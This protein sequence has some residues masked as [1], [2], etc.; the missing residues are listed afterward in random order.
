MTVELVGLESAPILA[1]DGA[2]ALGKGAII[3]AMLVSAAFLAGLAVLKKSSAAFCGFLMVVAA[4][5][6]QAVWL[7]VGP[8]PSQAILYLLQGL[9]AASG[10]LFISSTIGLIARSQLL[11]GILFA[12]ALSLVGVGVLN[13]AFGGE[14]AGLQR[15]AMIAAAAVTIGLA[16]F[17]G[18]RGDIGARLIMPGAALAAAAPLMLGVAGG[19]GA[20]SL[21]PQ[22]VFA[23]GV[24]VASL[25]ALGEFGGGRNMVMT[26]AGVASYFGDGA[27]AE[28]DQGSAHHRH[29]MRVAETKLAQVLDYAGIAVWDWSR[30]DSNQTATFGAVM[31]ADGDGAFTPE[32]FSEFIHADDR[33]RF[34]DKVFGV[35]EGDGGFDETIKLHSGKKVRMRGARAVDYAGRLERIVVFLEDSTSVA[36]LRRDDALKLAATSLTSA[37]AAAAAPAKDNKGARSDLVAAIED[38]GI[39]AAFQPI[40]SFDDGRVCGAEALLRWPSSDKHGA[41]PATEE[42]V[43]KAQAAGKG[44]AIARIMLD[45][46]AHH[47]CERLSTGDKSYFTAFNVSVSQVREPGF[48]DDVRKA[49]ADHKL[50]KGALVLEL[51]EGERLAETPKIVETFKALKAAGAALA[52]DDFGAGFSS[53]SNLHKYDFDYLKID[54]SFIDDIVA[55]GGK[56]KIVAALAKLGRDFDMGVIAEGVETK[57]A[58]EVAKAIGCR[59]GQGYYLGAPLVAAPAVAAG[60]EA[61]VTIERSAA[62]VAANDSGE[63]VL[64]RSMQAPHAPR[65]AFRR[66]LFGRGGR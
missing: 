25:V 12:G 19:S 40:I 31:G 11:G 7:G 54:K 52:Y 58:A 60:E 36:G 3:G 35:A 55:N 18:A 26:D 33:A 46:A 43:R 45:A 14:A 53:L 2:L 6:L 27:R 38:G 4:C 41:A 29:A 32:A 5:A 64:D 8:A 28:R 66:R 59:M 17:A 15:G 9:F 1:A 65:S 37:A 63:I 13:A 30:A 44:R 61:I 57:E 24:L 50:P 47:A 49:I 34:D 51:T 62:P 48:V 20:L 56:K 21:A 22:F 10:I 16:A 42:I 39:V 23:V